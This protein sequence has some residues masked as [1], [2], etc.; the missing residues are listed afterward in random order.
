MPWVLLRLVE[1][2]NMK[3]IK[4]LKW[5]DLI[6]H[7]WTYCMTI[8]CVVQEQLE[9]SHSEPRQALHFQVRGH[10]HQI[11]KIPLKLKKC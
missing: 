4:N 5:P 11:L 1:Q 8:H 3:W 10:I 9:E 7:L 2:I 6:I